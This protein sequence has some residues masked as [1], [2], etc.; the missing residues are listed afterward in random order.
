M[1]FEE[2]KP[3]LAKILESIYLDRSKLTHSVADGGYKGGKITALRLEQAVC[4]HLFDDYPE[5]FG[6]TEDEG[7]MLRDYINIHGGK[8]REYIELLHKEFYKFMDEESAWYINDTNNERL[9]L[10]L[11]PLNF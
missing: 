10:G 5:L 6:I 11:P 9:K 2:V 7:H 1:K 4:N 3:T 8:G